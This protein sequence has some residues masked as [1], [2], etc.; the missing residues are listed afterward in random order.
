MQG[1]PVGFVY[2]QMPGPEGYHFDCGCV[3][4][5]HGRMQRVRAPLE[6]THLHFLNFCGLVQDVRSQEHVGSW[7]T[8]LFISSQ[9]VAGLEV[10]TR[11]A[12]GRIADA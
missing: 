8:F 3:L 1:Y 6:N 5:Q 12:L 4:D 9:I 11:V 10:G 7:Y 2:G